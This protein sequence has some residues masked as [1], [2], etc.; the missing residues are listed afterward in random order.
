MSKAGLVILVIAL[1][2]M[3]MAS[4]IMYGKANETILIQ[5][6]EHQTLETN[7]LMKIVFEKQKE[8][9]SIK[10]KLNRAKISF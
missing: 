3:F 4:N 9:D 5:I 2:V 8:L 7:K 10:D 6:V 1:A